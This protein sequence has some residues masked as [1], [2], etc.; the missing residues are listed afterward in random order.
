[1][2]GGP[3]CCAELAQ[4]AVGISLERL[5][6]HLFP[7][8]LDALALHR[9]YDPFWDRSYAM[10]FVDLALGAVLMA[11]VWVAYAKNADGMTR[12]QQFLLGR[13]LADLTAFCEAVERVGG[14][15]ALLPPQQSTAADRALE[16]GE[17]RMRSSGPTVVTREMLK[18]MRLAVALGR[19]ERVL[20]QDTLLKRLVERGLA[21]DPNHLR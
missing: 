7:V 18:N 14:D 1:M 8:A 15:L 11:G 10:D 9:I 5:P 13:T 12:L 4:E 19:N 21:V 3:D 16:V 17:G 20:A 2:P 6:S